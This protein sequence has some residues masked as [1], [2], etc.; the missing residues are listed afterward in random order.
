[1]LCSR[2][3]KPPHAM[4]PR[5]AS[6]TSIERVFDALAARLRAGRCGRRS[7]SRRVDDGRLGAAARRHGLPVPDR[8]E[9]LHSERRHRPA[10]R[11]D[12][13][14]P[15]HRLRGDGRARSARSWTSSRTD[16]NVAAFT[17]NVGGNGGARSTSTSSRATER[18]LTADRDHRGAAAEAGARSGRARVPAEPAGD[19]HRRQPERAACT[20]SRC[21]IRTPTSCTASRRSSR[22]RCATSPGSQDV[23]SRPADHESAGRRRRSIAS[24][25]RRSASPSIRSSRRSTSAYGSRQ[26]S[27]IFAPNDEYQVIMQVAPQFQQRSR[28]RCRCSTCRRR[29]ASW[30]RC[31][32]S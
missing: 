19:P 7:A 3:L 15:G 6:T 32:R 1:M 30:C 17:A 4:Q 20:S 31:R 2:F 10:Q 27:Q 8:A 25:S 18:T 13:S 9:G 14:R 28:R 5:P 23:N 11:P 16:P 12:R 26:V 22:R 24:R 21:R 29:A